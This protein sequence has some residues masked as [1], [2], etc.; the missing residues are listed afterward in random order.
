MVYRHIN[1]I[2]PDRVRQDKLRCGEFELLVDLHLE[3]RYARHLAENEGEGLAGGYSLDR[4][5][6]YVF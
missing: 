5:A 6:L 3:R 4:G 1:G 2:V